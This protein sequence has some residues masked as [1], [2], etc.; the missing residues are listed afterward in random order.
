[1]VRMA[2]LAKITILPKFSEND[3]FAKS[4]KSARNPKVADIAM[5]AG[6]ANV[7]KTADNAKVAKWPRLVDLELSHF[8]KRS[9]NRTKLEK[10]IDFLW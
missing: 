10:G 9:I 8:S 6:L 3:N 7:T 2:K 5:V 1:M 4:V